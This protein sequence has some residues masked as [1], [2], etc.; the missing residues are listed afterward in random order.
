MPFRVNRPAVRHCQ[1]DEHDDG[2]AT[3]RLLAALLLFW[4]L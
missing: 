2:S 4:C 3:Y 1:S